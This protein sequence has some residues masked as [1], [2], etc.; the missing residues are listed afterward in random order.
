MQR[1]YTN[2]FALGN[3]VYERGYENGKRFHRFKYYKPT[4][5]IPSNKPSEFKTIDGL[6][7][8]PVQQDSIKSAKE[9][10]KRYEALENVDIYGSQLYPYVYLNEEFDN[11]YDAD[12]IKI[13]NFDV[14]VDSEFGF[15]EPASCTQEVQSIAMSITHKGKR[16]YF[17]FGTREYTGDTD[18]R[19]MKCADEK[20]LLIKFLDF[21]EA[22][23]PDV[24]TG[25]NIEV[26]DIP[27]IYR[28]ASKIISEDYAKKLSPVNIAFE[29]QVFQHNRNNITYDIVGLSVVD[30]L[31]AYKK[32]TYTQQES[33]TLNH[34]AHVVLG[35]RKLDYS[36]V[37]SLRALYRTNYNKFIDYNVEDVKLVDEI[38]DSEKIIAGIFAIS[39]DAKV[40]YTDVFS[41]VKLWDIIIHNFLYARKIVIPPKRKREKSAAYA[42]A[43]VK[44]PIVGMHDWLMSF[45]LDSLYPH[46]IMQYNISP[47]TFIEGEYTQFS[48]DDV[49]S[50]T[51]TNSSEEHSIA[52]NGH[53][54]RNDKQGFLAEIMETM[55]SERK[56]Y[57]RAQL[58]AEQELERVNARIKEI[59][60]L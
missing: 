46:L 13:V 56:Q 15:P 11:S 60:T 38:E 21:F 39:Y 54:F 43:Y 3:K 42:G 16:K 8:H 47:D 19:Y 28:R 35:K 30:Y 9:F 34:I 33:Y 7:V 40:N 51:I 50:R 22:V 27:Y 32:F 44:A 14:E 26:F 58:E 2:V 55:Y 24:L 57:K 5:F 36:E 10:C 18:A 20:D 53:H 1:F 59:E 17:V 37:Q 45:D 49:I 12:L 52:A 25:W 29:R 41:Q 4:L 6:T 48:I 23:D 31:Q